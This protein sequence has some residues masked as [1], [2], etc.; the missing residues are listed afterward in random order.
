MKY[1]SKRLKNA[2]YFLAFVSLSI[3]ILIEAKIIIVPILFSILLAL[4]L[5]PI[6]DFIKRRLRRNI[7]SIFAAYIVAVIPLLVLIFF[8]VNQARILFSELP[9]SRDKLQKLLV[10][11]SD[12]V[13]HKFGLEE[14]T[15]SNWI[16]EN[17]IT[18]LDVPVN[19]IRESL[20]STTALAAN[21]VLVAVITYFFLLYKSAFKN[22]ILTQVKPRNRKSAEKLFNNLQ[23]LTK[24]YL[25]GQGIVII[26]LGLLIGSGLWLIGVPY[27]YFW[28][29][30]AGFLEIIPYVGT[31]I[32][33]LLPFLYML[34]LAD[35]LWQPFAV[36]ALYILVQQ[37]EGNFI[38]PNVMGPS[39]KINPLFIILGLFA[40]GIIWGIAG[41]ILALP[42]LAISK[43]LLRSFEITRP[44]SYLMENGLSK[45][46]DIF[47][48]KYDAEKYRF[49]NL[50]F[51]DRP[52]SSDEDSENKFGS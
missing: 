39:I 50:L 41:M 36:I 38:S 13:D 24:R 40:G 28:G 25:A 51:R 32:G 22:Y 9:S 35:T 29:F 31:T 33:G 5:N 30:L 19:L 10:T 45:K 18:T 37:I 26:I 34:V 12:W 15:T 3:W 2:F 21:I 14:Q 1:Y 20:E 8:F 43:E 27:P 52:D 16:G 48:E 6:V 42:I 44:W 47:L 17:F 4:F 49:I 7:P 46:S 23:G 11:V